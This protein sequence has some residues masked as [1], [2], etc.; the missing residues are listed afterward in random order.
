MRLIKRIRSYFPSKLPVGLPQFDAWVAEIIELSGQFADETSMRFV[1]A[2]ELL[3][4]D[5]KKGSVPKNYFVSRC[6]KLAA[7]QTAGYILQEIK[8]EQEKLKAAEAA[9][10]A[11][12][13][14]AALPKDAAIEEA[15]PET[16][17]G[18][19]TKAH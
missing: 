12:E 3:H 4:S 9:K 17:S 6:R 7:N 14:T 19:G 18:V 16:N 5:A 1:L 2:S 11:A 15:K 8:A 10:L 13:A